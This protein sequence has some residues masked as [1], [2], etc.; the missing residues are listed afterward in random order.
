MV[1]IIN[2]ALRTG[3]SHFDTRYS[4]DLID[5]DA[6]TSLEP[7]S[8]HPWIMIRET[9]QLKGWVR[10]IP[11]AKLESEISLDNSLERIR[12]FLSK[13]DRASESGD[14]HD[15]LGRRQ[16]SAREKR[17]SSGIKRTL[18]W[19]NIASGE[20]D[21]RDRFTATW[22][23]LESILN[24]IT[25][26]GV[27]DGERSALKDEITREVRKVSLPSTSRQSLDI[28]KDML[29]NRILQNNWSLPRK[30][31]IFAESLGVNL[32]PDDKKL[33]GM[34]SRARNTILHGGR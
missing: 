32:K 19:L 7:V 8:L 31:P 9:S 5:F 10:V 13:F 11:T 30:L 27:F 28:T 14:V 4:G 26:P 20:D 15:Q 17:L 22:I 25:Y 3:M 1:V 24:S 2:L 6:E 33:V 21:E 23:A 29:E 12:F 34:L 16:L 18:R